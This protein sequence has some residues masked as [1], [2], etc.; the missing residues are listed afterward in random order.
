MGGCKVLLSSIPTA[1]AAVA[2]VSG[3]RLRVHLPLI[4]IDRHSPIACPVDRLVQPPDHSVVYD[5]TGCGLGLPG[6]IR[7]EQLAVWRQAVTAA[8]AATVQR[9][10]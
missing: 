9:R 4:A 6:R 10:N 8:V 1:A 3:H 7:V 2:P 5:T